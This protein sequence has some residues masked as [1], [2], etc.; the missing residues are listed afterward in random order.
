MAP[1]KQAESANNAKSG[2][3]S[4]RASVVAVPRAWLAGLTALVVVPWLIVSAVYFS[5]PDSTAEEG[6]GEPAAS[7]A[8]GSGPWGR[9]E[10]TPIIVSPPLEYVSDDWGREDKPDQWMF[11]GVS[12]EE[13]QAFLLAAGFT[14]D[15][16]ARIVTSA[17]PDPPTGGLVIMPDS[18]LVRS[19]A[20]EVRGRLYT[21]L[22]KTRLNF[23]QMNSFRFFGDSAAWLNGSLISPAT[24]R[25]LEPLFYRDGEFLHFADPELVR[26][27]VKDPAE[28]RRVAKTLL[29]QSTML[30]RLSVGEESEVSGLV[31]YWGCGGRRTDLRPLLE[32]MAGRGSPSIDIA[33]LLPAFAR[34]HLYRYPKPTT[35]DF[36]LPLLANCLWTALNFFS[37]ELDNRFLDVN[38]AVETLK[39]DYFV[40]KSGFQLGDV[41]SL[42]DENGH[43]FHV[44]VYIADGLVFPKNGTS[45]VSPWIIMPVERLKA[46]Y[47]GRSSS[48]QLVYHRHGRL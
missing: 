24:R 15:Q 8:A 5:P 43:L 18:E 48:P 1:T 14:A 27:Q 2:R 19:L 3:D 11:P 40:V 44:A 46:Y 21:Q 10:I 47:R 32:S 7:V 4:A 38:V 36:D 26:A 45:P 37:I 23:D 20:P 13:L 25:I 41:L 42:T 12:R 39:R 29:R 30:V 31:E 34:N 33:H 22:A 9:L 6:A 28:L 17:R 16:T 35:A